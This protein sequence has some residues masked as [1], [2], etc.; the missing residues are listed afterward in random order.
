VEILDVGCISSFIR[1][2]RGYQLKSLGMLVRV[3]IRACPSHWKVASA[4]A[5]YFCKNHCSLMLTYIATQA[6]LNQTVQH[7]KSERG[8]LSNTPHRIRYQQI[9]DHILDL[10]NV[11][12]KSSDLTGNLT[13]M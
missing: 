3:E 13:K 12:R 6:A 5:V 2:L 11:D 9:F 4:V 10:T 7:M 1:T 8:Q